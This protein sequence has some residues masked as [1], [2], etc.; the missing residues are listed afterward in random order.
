MRVS[1]Q[2]YLGCLCGFGTGTSL[3]ETKLVLGFEPEY[4]LVLHV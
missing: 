3:P 2:M 1:A 4:N